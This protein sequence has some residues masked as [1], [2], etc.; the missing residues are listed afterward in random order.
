MK[1][2][3]LI[4]IS[5]F[6]KAQKKKSN[7]LSEFETPESMGRFRK[8]SLDSS[9]PYFLNKNEMEARIHIVARHW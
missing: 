6:Q 4:S 2:K 5:S 3:G 8:I 7:L 9:S 1:R